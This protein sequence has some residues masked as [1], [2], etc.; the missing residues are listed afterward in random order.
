MIA[1]PFVAA[2]DVGFTVLVG[3]FA[4][5]GAVLSALAAREALPRARRGIAWLAILAGTLG[6]IGELVATSATAIAL[7]AALAWVPVVVIAELESGDARGG[8]R[9]ARLLGLAT[10]AVACGLLAAAVI[11]VSAGPS[12]LGSARSGAATTLG[13]SAA[14][15]AAVLVLLA[16]LA[17]PWCALASRR[18][19]G[20]AAGTYLVGVAA[21]AGGAAALRVLGLVFLADGTDVEGAP[22]P[23]GLLASSG[24]ASHAALL[25]ACVAVL[26]A[27]RA[28]TL[29]ALVAR[30]ALASGACSFVAAAGGS[31]SA[32]LTALAQ[33][34]ATG[35]VHAALFAVVA[36]LAAD[37]GRRL[38]HLAGA[39][40]RLSGAKLACLA[41]LAASAGLPPTIA[42]PARLATIE[43]VLHAGFAI[44]ALLVASSTAFAMLAAARFS[45][46]LLARPAPETRAT[47]GRPA[48]ALSIAVVAVAA[49]AVL[50][51]LHSATFERCVGL[52]RSLLEA[53]P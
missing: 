34:L 28:R 45:L 48:V 30:L 11:D 12:S 14:T 51:G 19:V 44:P 27:L 46:A 52:A 13:S 4:A 24:G 29:V 3:S 21:L 9:S 7:C 41:L 49:V 25:A 39:A 15:R 32:F 22:A 50:G 17:S 16:A 36:R 31:E 26:D 5:A 37:G 10:L 53:A 1:A 23:H 6:A 18:I 47:H 43:Q 42:F 35:L 20:P 40:G 8:S 2:G 38:E 33:L